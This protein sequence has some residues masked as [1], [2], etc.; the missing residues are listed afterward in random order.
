MANPHKGDVPLKVGDRIYT[1]RYSHLALV[2]LEDVLGKNL[3]GIMR[4]IQDA[5][6]MRLG[7]VV[8]LLWAGLQKHHPDVSRDDAA[9]LIDDISGGMAATI[10]IVGVA[11]QKAFGATPGTKGTNPTSK[12]SNGTGT[13]S[14]SSSSA[15]GTMSEPSGGSHLSTS[16][17]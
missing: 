7:T 16:G 1:L 15:T 8:A 17:S 3:Q 11:F 4:E 9:E 5:E 10:G 12:A 6:E 13:S 2:K 14:S